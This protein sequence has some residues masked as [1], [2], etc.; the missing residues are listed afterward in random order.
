MLSDRR[1][2]TLPRLAVGVC[3]GALLLGTAAGCQTTQE[4]AAKHQAVAEIHDY[5]ATLGTSIA[6][7]ILRR[8]LNADDQR[9]LVNS[10]VEQLKTVSAN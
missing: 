5:A 10:S 2:P 3:A 4:K 9:D 6:E 1:Q 7:K 8:N